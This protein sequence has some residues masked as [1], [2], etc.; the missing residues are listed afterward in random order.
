MIFGACD[1]RKT[2]CTCSKTVFSKHTFRWHQSQIRR[3]EKRTKFFLSSDREMQ[4][5]KER[6]KNCSEPNYTFGFMC[7]ICGVS[8]LGLICISYIQTFL[9]SLASVTAFSYVDYSFDRND[10]KANPCTSGRHSIL[11]P[12]HAQNK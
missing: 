7:P 1:K 3:N 2:I 5:K 8:Q 9:S 11:Q 10:Y 4:K 6:K 12:A